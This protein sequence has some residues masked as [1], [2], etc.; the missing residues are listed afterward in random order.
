MPDLP[1]VTCLCPTYERF[2]RLRDAVGCFLRQDYPRRRLLILNDAP[3]PIRPGAARAFGVEVI[4]TTLR[5]PTLGHKRQTLLEAARTPLVAHWDDDDLYLPWHLSVLVERLRRT[6]ASCVKPRAAWWAVGPP[7]RW[8]LR[9]IRHNVFEGQML[10]RRERA[11]ELGGYPPIDSGQAKELLDAFKAAGELCTWNPPPGEVSYIYR[12]ADGLSHVSAG[13]E[14]P[15]APDEGDFGDRSLLACSDAQERRERDS[16]RW[17]AA[18]DTPRELRQKSC[19]STDAIA[20]AD[21]VPDPHN[22]RRKERCYRIAH[23][24]GSSASHG[25]RARCF[26]SQLPGLTRRARGAMMAAVAFA[27][28]FGRLLHGRPSP[29][30]RCCPSQAGVRAPVS[31][32]PRF[33]RQAWAGGG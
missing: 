15:A 7:R 28:G 19:A 16:T 22:H 13:G 25:K 3:R 23:G 21:A 27:S 5:Y 31:V 11:L 1:P 33:L 6:G 14:G 24:Y 2:S 4:N 26:P 18:G 10:F 12:W 8:R 20:R 9:G 30:V 29:R 17:A 32:R